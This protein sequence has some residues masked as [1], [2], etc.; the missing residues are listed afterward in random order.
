LIAALESPDLPL[1]GTAAQALG[2]IGP[3][4]KRALPALKRL[5]RQTQ[6]PASPPGSL[7]AV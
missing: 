5:L 1:R 2:R 7:K 6:E 3:E 4:A